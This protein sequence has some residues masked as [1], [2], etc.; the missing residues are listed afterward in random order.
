MKGYYKSNDVRAS[1]K[2]TGFTFR[3]IP[4]RWW[5]TNSAGGLR[6]Q[7]ARLP[8]TVFEFE[9]VPLRVRFWITILSVHG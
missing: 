6:D 3:I 5:G 4:E 7:N 8:K 1:R 9:I 2:P